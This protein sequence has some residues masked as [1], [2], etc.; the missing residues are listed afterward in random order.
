MIGLCKLTYDWGT[1][2]QPPS[3]GCYLRGHG[4]RGP[5]PRAYLIH[6]S[7]LVK[8]TLHEGRYV[9]SCERMRAADIPEEAVVYPIY[10]YSRTRRR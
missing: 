8:S 9:L 10:W 1:E 4:V 7:R 3:A 6:S 2:G 5:S